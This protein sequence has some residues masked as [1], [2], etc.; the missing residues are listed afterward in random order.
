M[1][2]AI[3]STSSPTIL[4]F[5]CQVVQE[6]GSVAFPATMIFNC[7]VSKIEKLIRTFCMIRSRLNTEETFKGP[8]RGIIFVQIHAA[9]KHW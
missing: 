8:F 4:L 5:V 9:E 7:V 1:I 6:A 2:I 3:S